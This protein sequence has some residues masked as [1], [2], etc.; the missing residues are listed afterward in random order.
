VEIVSAAVPLLGL[1]IAYRLFLGKQWS[2]Q[3]LLSNPLLQRVRYFWLNHWGL[4]AL[5]DLLL[6]RPYYGLANALSSEPIDRLYGAIVWFNQRLHGWLSRTQGGRVRSYISSM[7]LGL[8]LLMVLS[9]YGG[10]GM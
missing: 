7:V 4:D 6:V 10:G 5:Y 9:L 2:L 1:G 3:P 8:L